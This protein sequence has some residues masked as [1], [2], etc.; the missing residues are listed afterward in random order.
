M[1]E[2][3]KKGAASCEGAPPV[4]QIE[5][6][7][8]IYASKFNFQVFPL[9]PRG[10]TPK[11]A[12]GFKDGSTDPHQIREWWSRSPHSNLGIV[13]GRVSG[14]CVL[15]IDA[16]HNG[17]N[18]LQDLEN[19]FGP[20]PLT[21]S[22][23]TGGGG[24]H[25]FFKHPGQPV[26]IRTGIMEGV[27]F[28]GD[29]GYVCASPS[30]HNSGKSYLWNPGVGLDDVP[31]A[32]M[33]SWLIELL[34]GSPGGLY[35]TRIQDGFTKSRDPE[36][37]RDLALN[38]ALEGFRNDSVARLIGHLLRRNIDPYV[39]RD[40]V[41]AWNRIKNSPPLRDEEVLQI[42]DSIAKKECLRKGSK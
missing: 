10:K 36:Y 32:Q 8:Q 17:F 27:D 38:G 22:C 18:S 7:A 37:W 42:I 21:P 12:H 5:I 29:G 3:N 31:L 33:P 34:V 24:R 26:N 19:K 15:D 6:A 16:G 30:I 4:N 35:S 28:R 9:Q 39:A 2:N 1:N 20:L 41:F 13:T 11:T 25:Y 23:S 40:L 14:V